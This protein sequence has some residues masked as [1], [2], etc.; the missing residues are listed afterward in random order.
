[1][2]KDAGKSQKHRITNPQGHKK[3]GECS[4]CGI[5]EVRNDGNGRFKC[6]NSS[7]IND[8]IQY[9]KR[10]GITL[11]REQATPPDKC[12]VCGCR[13]SLRLDHNH[14]TLEIRGWLCTWCNTALGH[15]RDSV[16]ILAKLQNYLIERGSYNRTHLLN[17]NSQSLP[18]TGARY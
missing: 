18:T 13:D 2:Q 5:V 9:F 4:V 3:N 7:R 10:A 17:K 14:D 8:R 1:M 11:T 15:A 16:E 12:E 6:L